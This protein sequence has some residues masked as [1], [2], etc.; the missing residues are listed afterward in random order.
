MGMA[1]FQGFL[2]TSTAKEHLE[3]LSPRVRAILRKLVG[4]DDRKGIGLGLE[5]SRRDNAFWRIELDHSLVLDC[6]LIDKEVNHE[7]PASHTTFQI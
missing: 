1:H 7:N 4:H 5:F 6:L 2:Y 3:T